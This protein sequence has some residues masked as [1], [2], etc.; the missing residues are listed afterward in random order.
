MLSYS[1]NSPVHS[2][3][4]IVAVVT[5]DGLIQLDISI[6][7]LDQE[8][9][10]LERLL[11]LPGQQ[12]NHVGEDLMYILPDTKDDQGTPAHMRRRKADLVRWAMP[13]IFQWVTSEKDQNAHP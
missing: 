12:L 1:L 4:V 8:I 5:F 7:Q 11:Q 10:R 3:L 13:T 2:S 6:Y 9:A